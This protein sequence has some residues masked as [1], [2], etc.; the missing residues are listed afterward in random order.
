MWIPG[1]GKYVAQ[2]GNR[3]GDNAPDFELIDDSGN[4]VRLSEQV[5]NLPVVLVFYPKAGTPG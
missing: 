4:R 2:T 3:V 1:F 5:G